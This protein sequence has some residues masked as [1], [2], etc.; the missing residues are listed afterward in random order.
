MHSRMQKGSLFI[1]VGLPTILF[2]VIM[3][4]VTGLDFWWLAVA[5]GA[6]V[7]TSGGIQLSQNLK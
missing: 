5:I 6:A 4:K 7:G 2:G 3:L 1:F